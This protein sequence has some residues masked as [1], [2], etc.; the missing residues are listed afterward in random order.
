M[1]NEFSNEIYT[2]NDKN[3]ENIIEN[4]EE[5]Q[6]KV[7]E[8]KYGILNVKL[9]MFNNILKSKFKFYF[10]FF[11]N[12]IF[13]KRSFINLFCESDNFLEIIPKNHQ[14]IDYYKYYSIKKLIYTIKDIKFRH[15]LVK[16]SFLLWKSQTKLLPKSI[17]KNNEYSNY[18]YNLIFIISKIIHKK[19]YVFYLK[20]IF[21][22]LWI[23]KIKKSHLRTKRGIII[24]QNLLNRKISNYFYLIPQNYFYLKYKS[25][26]IK[27][28][29][30]D[31]LKKFVI[32]DKDIYYKTLI[33]Y[34]SLRRKVK[35]YKK[36][37]ILLKLF[38]KIEIKNY[39]NQNLFQAFYKL[40]FFTYTF[41]SINA[42]NKKLN[43]ILLNLK[44][45][46]LINSSLIIKTILNNKIKNSILLKKRKFFNYLIENRN[47]IKIISDYNNKY[48]LLPSQIEDKNNSNI[49]FIRNKFKKIILLRNIFLIR[50]KHKNIFT[51]YNI[52]INQSN[53]IQ[54]YFN[55]WTKINNYL[56]TKKEIKL[57]KLY[58]IDYLLKKK[59]ILNNGN[60]FLGNLLIK[61][62]QKTFIH[63]YSKQYL[64]V[65]I[66]SIRNILYKKLMFFLMRFKF[67]K[68]SLNI[69]ENQKIIKLK[70]LFL[71]FHY[72]KKLKKKKRKNYSYSELCKLYQ[73]YLLYFKQ[74]IIKY[75]KKWRNN[76]RIANIKSY[77]NNSIIIDKNIFQNMTY[78]LLELEKKDDGLNKEIS[79]IKKTL[80]KPNILLE[81]VLKKHYGTLLK[82]F[83]NWYKVINSSSSLCDLYL[84]SEKIKEENNTL[85]N[86]YYEK[87]NQFKKIICDYRYMK[88]HYC[89]KCIGEDLEI[90][91]KSIKSDELNEIEDMDTINMNDN[92]ES[93]ILNTSDEE[94][95]NENKQIQDNTSK[96]I[97]TVA[98]RENRIKEYQN[99]YKKLVEEYE[100]TI[101]DLN[102]KKEELLELKKQFLA[103]KY[104]N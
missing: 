6:E 24:I 53:N 68:Y 55:K 79:L 18:V 17:I 89:E 14:Q 20:K 15:Y 66:S 74:K 102:K 21:L 50:I 73:L 31:F 62:Y 83:I 12:K 64:N 37:S 77:K 11:L 100:E 35:F 67:Y 29:L 26:V 71:Y 63:N 9:S 95:L 94:V 92:Y 85:I 13:L 57:F 49:C 40:R 25:N 16:N 41:S 45:D 2:S 88:K 72:F 104:S 5:F 1:N 82:Y 19:N 70:Q 8:I 65:L 99:E 4:I 75:I 101:S 60:K 3:N 103:K 46:I 78:I 90:D 34:Y 81:L 38:N 27:E 59:I 42:E 43:E 48:N 93:N 91:Y 32:N 58:E 96:S 97:N 69:N 44:C 54:K 56:K 47:V 30:K 7:N 23:E 76:L 87:K 28:E 52:Y 51:E 61:S 86:K 84:Q 10:S 98:E 33:D 36:K 22:F 39:V 80:N